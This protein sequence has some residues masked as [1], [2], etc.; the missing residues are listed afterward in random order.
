ML[1][2]FSILALA[3]Q[4]LIPVA[5]KVPEFNIERGYKVDNTLSSLAVAWTNR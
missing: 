3:S 5:D 2:R 1:L 4:L